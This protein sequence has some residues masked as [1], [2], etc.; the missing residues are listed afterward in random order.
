MFFMFLK[1]NQPLKHKIYSKE[2]ISREILKILTLFWGVKK[3]KI[4]QKVQ[5]PVKFKTALK[6]KEQHSVTWDKTLFGKH[7]TSRDQTNVSDFYKQQACG[8]AQEEARGNKDEWS[9][10]QRW[11]S[12][13][14]GGVDISIHQQAP[15]LDRR[16]FRWALGLGILPPFIWLLGGK[17]MARACF[18]IDLF[19]SGSAGSDPSGGVLKQTCPLTRL[20]DWRK[21]RKRALTTISEAW[22]VISDRTCQELYRRFTQSYEKERREQGD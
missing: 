1:M 18:L 5:N 17:P 7:H 8:C 9:R 13:W 22:K 11:A 14:R 20:L 19:M 3:N 12:E 6:F 4:W 15:F 2:I 10:M 21:M 16:S